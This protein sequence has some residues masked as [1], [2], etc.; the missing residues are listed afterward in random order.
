MGI[1][2]QGVL[3]GIIATFVIDIWAIFVKR[4]LRLPTANWALVGRWFGY[5]PR[6]KF[7][8]RP[9]ADSAAIP[10]ELTIG[11]IAH[12]VTGIFYGVAYLG[13]VQGILSR[14]PTMTSALSFGLLTLV[15]PWLI[16]QPG[17]GAGVFASRTPRPGVMRLVNVSMHAIFG[18]SLYAA[19]LLI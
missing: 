13:I 1:V 18:A 2:I 15:A 10:N 14:S 17:M 8:H 12:Y 4:M 5:L 6:G 11:W 19:W 9:I 16:L 3:I 7:I